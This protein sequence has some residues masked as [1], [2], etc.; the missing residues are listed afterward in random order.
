M[1]N[2]LSFTHLLKV[3][4]ISIAALMGGCTQGDW[5]TASREPAGIAPDPYN[6]KHA[7]IEFYAADAFGWRG[8]FAVH[9]WFAIKPENA[10][11]YTVYE[12]VGWR[13]NRGQPALYQYQTGTPDRYW[14]GAKPEKYSQYKVKKPINLSQ[15]YKALST[16]TLGLKNTR[17]FQDQIAIHSRLGWASKFRS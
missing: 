2:S 17:C 3:G 11:E 1:K 4:L 10:N 6:V 12:V 5:R 15:K 13:V 14:Y 16:N 9:T 7:V 8:W